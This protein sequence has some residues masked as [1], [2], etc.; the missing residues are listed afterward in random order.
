MICLAMICKNESSLIRTALAS[1]KPFIDFWCV[2]DTGSTDNTKSVVLEE[3]AGI[4][5]TLFERPWVNWEW[6]RSEAIK[7]ARLSGCDFI[8]ILDADEKV[9][10]PLGFKLDLNQDLA[11]W[12]T[13]QF[14]TT[15]YGR[16]NILSVKHNWHYVG[17]THEY[18]TAQPDNPSVVVLPLTLQTNIERTNKTPEKCA[19][20]AELLENALLTEPDNARYIFYAAQ[21]YR[22]SSQLEKAIEYYTRRA[23][24]GGWYEECFYALFQVAELKVRWNSIH[25][26]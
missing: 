20:D 21:S 4:P 5:G 13:K 9:I 11:Y 25:E 18:L 12:V 16:P 7:L 23:C 10:P 3:M 6:N 26:K 17:V 8:F 15:S 19:L 14:G 24:M 22:D 1:V 2:V